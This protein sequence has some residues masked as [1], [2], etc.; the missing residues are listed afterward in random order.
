MPRMI[1]DQPFRV[2][3]SNCNSYENIVLDPEPVGIYAVHAGTS[4]QP[5]NS[6]VKLNNSPFRESFGRQDYFIHQHGSR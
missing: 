1:R 4:I 2:Y 3:T 5:T 6:D